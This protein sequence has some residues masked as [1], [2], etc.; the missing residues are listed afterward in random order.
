MNIAAP[1]VFAAAFASATAAASP[2]FNGNAAIPGLEGSGMQVLYEFNVTATNPSYA[3]GNPVPYTVNN[4]ASVLAG[5]TR[6]GY[7]V[8]VTSGPQKGLF[9]YVSM[10]SFDN[11]P[12]RL[13]V[14]HNRNNPV[15]RQGLV[16]NANVFSNNGGIVTG[17]G[18]GQVSLEMW[19][20]NYAT[21]TTGY[22]T[23]GNG[24]SFDYNDSG[25]NAGQG[26]GS[27][28]VH[29]IG[30][31]QTLFAWNDWGGNSPGQRSEFGI[32][33]A[34]ANYPHPD[35]TFSDAGQTG[36]I[37]IVVGTPSKVPEPASLGL[38]GLGLAAAGIARRRKP[39][40]G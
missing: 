40:Q 34:P 12:A 29:N 11:N 5:Y 13:A 22:A 35:W 25:F 20:S 37:Q 1:F 33:N 39:A 30:A 28:Q 21:G 32:G 6:V 18:F 3:N 23:G 9:V 38:L 31:G 14:P 26:H 15:A 17:T 36:I 8:E 2:L 10:D 19:P 27:L 4:L 16:A 24:G 7:Y